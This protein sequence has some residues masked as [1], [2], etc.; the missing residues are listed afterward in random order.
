M[1]LLDKFGRRRKA[2]VAQAPIPPSVEDKQKKFPI[3]DELAQ[4]GRFLG[5]SGYLDIYQNVK[6]SAPGQNYKIYFYYLGNQRPV[7]EVEISVLHLDDADDLRYQFLVSATPCPDKDNASIG[8]IDESFISPL[9]ASEIAKFLTQNKVKLKDNKPV[10]GFLPYAYHYGDLGNTF[11]T[12]E[13]QRICHATAIP[14]Y[15]FLDSDYCFNT[16]KFPKS[17]QFQ[18]PVGLHANSL[19]I[20]HPGISGEFGQDCRLRNLTVGE[21]NNKDI[22]PISKSLMVFGEFIHPEYQDPLPKRLNA[23]REYINL[24]DMER[25]QQLVYESLLP[26]TLKSLLTAQAVGAGYQY[27]L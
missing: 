11:L 10:R 18:M 9:Y 1:F 15:A 27:A 13:E 23:M 22:L 20:D 8:P 19:I 3:A 25:E 14:D 17:W 6:C 12:L 5:M 7:A 26:Y 2:A 16:R 4:T 21:F 24:R